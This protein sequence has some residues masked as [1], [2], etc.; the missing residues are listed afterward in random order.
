MT[1]RANK[2]I[3]ILEEFISAKVSK[4][5]LMSGESPEQCEKRSLL[6]RSLALFST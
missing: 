3:G 4:S 1:L 2:R 5:V 6:L